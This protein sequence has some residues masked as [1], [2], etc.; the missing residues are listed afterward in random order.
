MT[1]AAAAWCQ[2]ED[3]H[4]TVLDGTGM[5]L[6]EVYPHPSST[7]V[8]TELQRRQWLVSS[9][10]VLPG[11]NS[12][13]EIAH[14][15]V[16]RKVEGQYQTLLAHSDLPGQPKGLALFEAWRSWL[17]LR[18]SYPIDYL[19]QLEGRLAY[20]YFRTWEGWQLQWAKPDT[21]RVPPHW[22]TAR[23]RNS[24]LSYT[25]S[26]RHA[27]DPLNA[28]L[29]YCYA[30]LASQCRQSLLAESFSLAAGFLHFDKP[31]RD[32]LT[33]DLEE[34]ERGAVDDLLLTFL[35]KTVLHYGDFARD[36]KGKVT[37]HPQLTRLLLAECRVPQSRVDA[38]ARWL[39][40]LLFTMPKRDDATAESPSE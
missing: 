6:L 23:A 1:L 19:R 10:V 9:G 7:P 22:L 25:N 17:N 14:E 5:P 26:G 21:R 39:K 3:V 2:R 12:A 36:E 30:C 20:A 40:S 4:L 11:S 34:L 15:I 33:Y 37:L 13:S 31:G 16:K 28:C 27:V 35:S 8:D 29:N 32:S 24:P 18:Q 38:H